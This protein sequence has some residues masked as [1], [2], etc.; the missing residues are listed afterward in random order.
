MTSSP[1]NHPLK[2]LSIQLLPNDLKYLRKIKQTIYTSM[3]DKINYVLQERTEK[4]RLLQ[5]RIE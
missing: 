4:L 1:G 5:K 3:N 2:P